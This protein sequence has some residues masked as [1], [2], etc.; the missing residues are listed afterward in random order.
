MNLFDTDGLRWKRFTG[1]TEYGYPQDYSAAFLSARKDGH[2]EFVYRWEPN[3]RCE[4]HR[5]R[6]QLTS[7]VLEGEL[8]VIDIDPSTGQETGRK[9]RPTGDYVFKE[10]GDVHIEVGGNEG[11]LVLFNLYAPDGVMVEG[12]NT[13]GSVAGVSTTQRIMK[14]LG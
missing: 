6:C 9:V 5:H 4:L 10:P 8:H 13:D 2:V 1:P 7:L 11:A 14:R 3:C 12:L